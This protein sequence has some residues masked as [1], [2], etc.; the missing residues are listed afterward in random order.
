MHEM[1]SSWRE[2]P[3][4]ETLQ[5]ARQIAPGLGI[6]RV[7][8]ITWLDK[9]GIPVFSSVRPD[10]LQG[11]LCVNAGKGSL[12]EEARVGAYMEA[13]EFAYAE[14]RRFHSD[15]FLSTPAKIAAQHNFSCEFVDLCPLWRVEVDPD[16]PIDSLLATDL[17]TQAEVAIPAE[18]VFAPFPEIR[19][20]ALFGTGT[21]GLC[22]GNSI[23]EAVLHG[24]CEVIERDVQAFNFMRDDSRFVSME[25]LP[26]KVVALVDKIRAAGL[27]PALRYTPNE[28]GLPYF[29]GYVIADEYDPI[30]VSHGTGLHLSAEIAAV[31][32]ISEAAQSRLS[33]IHG[34]RDNLVHRAQFFAEHGKETERQAVARMRQ[35]VLDETTSISFAE[36]PHHPC[37]SIRSGIHELAARL[38]RSGIG[39]IL[40]VQLTPPSSSLVVVKVMVPKLECFNPRQK[41]VG[42]R[43]IHQIMKT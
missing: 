39:Q 22:S 27:I 20:Q 9:I 7:M 32:A 40:Y 6:S 36:I 13:I 24:L 12:P 30:T 10:A 29:Q 37:T 26:A 11:S 31:R 43:L 1:T 19:G 34:G 2:R 23:D 42:P 38:A 4:S 5:R 17:M 35:A 41:R 28:F 21:N 3:L 18:L 14:R 16:E 8:D 25:G 15:T 33:Y